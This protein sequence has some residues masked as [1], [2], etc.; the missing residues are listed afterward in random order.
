M[1]HPDMFQSLKPPRAKRR[2]MMHAIDCGSRG[3]T[4]VIA[5]FECA[6]CGNKSEWRICANWTDME[7]G[8]PCPNC[9]VDAK[10]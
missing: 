7:R 8:E 2:V 10:P 5:L 3:P 9:N 4:D 6:K 1:P